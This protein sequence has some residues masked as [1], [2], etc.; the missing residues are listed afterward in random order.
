M[1]ARNDGMPHDAPSPIRP[2]DPLAEARALHASIENLRHAM[3]L[4]IRALDS[5]ERRLTPPR[6]EGR[7]GAARLRDLK[8]S[9]LL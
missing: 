9:G 4:Q 5:L 6:P 3:R 8:A 1:T 7:Q 2:Y